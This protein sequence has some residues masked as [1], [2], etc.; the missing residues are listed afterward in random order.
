MVVMDFTHDPSEDLVLGNR[1][2]VEWPF[3][4]TIAFEEE[5]GFPSKAIEMLG[6]GFDHL[7]P[8]LRKRNQ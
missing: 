6:G 1:T 7:P 2:S 5:W 8:C 4:G 3:K